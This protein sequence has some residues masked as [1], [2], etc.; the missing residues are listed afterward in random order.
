MGSYVIGAVS[1]SFD[2]LRC[3]LS[4]LFTWT[5][6]NRYELGLG[7]VPL[8]RE[9]QLRRGCKGGSPFEKNCM[10]VRKKD[11]CGKLTWI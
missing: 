11:K 3:V 6:V 7:K 9:E 2:A 4:F 10:C 1:F 5:G 8:L